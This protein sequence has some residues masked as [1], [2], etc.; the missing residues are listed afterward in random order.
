MIST[1]H[2]DK[3][4]KVK[5]KRE[6]EKEEPLSVLAYN[7]NIILKHPVAFTYTSHTVCTVTYAT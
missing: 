4:R 1:Y 5:T 6:E 2:G 3:M 7:Q